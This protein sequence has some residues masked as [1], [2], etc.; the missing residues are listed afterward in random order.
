MEMRNKGALPVLLLLIL[1]V[2]CSSTVYA[3][4]PDCANPPCGSDVSDEVPAGGGMEDDEDAVTPLPEGADLSVLTIDEPDPLELGNM[5]HYKSI[6]SNNGPLQA[7]G[8]WLVIALPES[9]AV[10]GEPMVS[11]GEC[12]KVNAKI[13][14][15]LGTIKKGGKV[16]VSFNVLFTLAGMQET[17]LEVG[18]STRDPNL[19]N[20]KESVSTEVVE[21][22]PGLPS[23]SS[24]AALANTNTVFEIVKLSTSQLGTV[25]NP[26]WALYN[27]KT[28]ENVCILWNPN[29]PDTQVCTSYFVNEAVG[30]FINGF[31]IELDAIKSYFPQWLA[32]PDFEAVVASNLINGGNGNCIGFATMGSLALSGMVPF[33]IM[34]G[35]DKMNYW[36]HQFSDRNPDQVLNDLFDL[37]HDLGIK[38]SNEKLR[39]LI[40]RGEVVNGDVLVAR[41]CPGCPFAGGVDSGHGG[42]IMVTN[43]SHGDY[44]VIA[45]FGSRRLYISDLEM[46][47]QTDPTHWYDKSPVLIYRPKPAD[48]FK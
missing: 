4:I 7:V 33:R 12:T 30:V 24:T 3:K 45:T 6:V 16:Q 25:D 14:C 8:A 34:L 1:I 29:R 23:C 41:P 32:N 38:P 2:L 18:S 47:W 31:R 42:L 10:N 44:L 36:I 27:P 21:N 35:N 40:K 19:Q 37:T 22:G 43:Q 15:Q 20:N 48:S 46:Y 5:L 9:A 13:S 17:K 28:K 11:Q 26:A 39:G